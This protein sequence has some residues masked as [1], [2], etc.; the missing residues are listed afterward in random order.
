MCSD[1]TFWR[2]LTV[3][4]E[5]RLGFSMNGLVL[6]KKRLRTMMAGVFTVF[7]TVVPFLLTLYSSN[8]DAVA[9]YGQ[10]A[11]S[12]VVYAYRRAPN[13]DVHGRLSHK[14]AM[15]RAIFSRYS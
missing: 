9:I 8:N 5:R 10:M 12:S 11:N 15:L 4:A 3:A 6:D 2:T 1:A 14:I 7:A 13:L